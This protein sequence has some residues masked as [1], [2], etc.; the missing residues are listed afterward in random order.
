MDTTLPILIPFILFHSIKT[1]GKKKE[2]LWSL[3]SSLNSTLKSVE[4]RKKLNDKHNKKHFWDIKLYRK[5]YKLN[6]LSFL[7]EKFHVKGKVFIHFSGWGK[8]SQ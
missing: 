8:K 6:L 3:N 7:N 4:L 2:L 5:K 1:Y